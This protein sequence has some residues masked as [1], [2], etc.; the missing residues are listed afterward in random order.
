MLRD[1]WSQVFAGRAPDIVGLVCAEQNLNE[2]THREAIGAGVNWCPPSFEAPPAQ[3]AGVAPQDDGRR[4]V[5]VANCD[6]RPLAN[7]LQAVFFR[8]RRRHLGLAPV[9]AG[10]ADGLVSHGLMI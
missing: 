3:E 9:A 5:L 1:A 2:C 4:V 10:G 8:N 7:A 6:S